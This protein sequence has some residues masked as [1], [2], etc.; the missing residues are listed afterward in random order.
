[1]GI[2][3]EQAYKINDPAALFG[4][5]FHLNIHNTAAAA[6]QRARPGSMKR[7]YA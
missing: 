2:L 3:K 1:M 6:P 7:R 4:T 5:A